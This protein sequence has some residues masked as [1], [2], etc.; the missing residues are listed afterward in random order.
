MLLKRYN[1]RN[2]GPHGTDLAQH[3][4][5]ICTFLTDTL[6]TEGS[7]TPVWGLALILDTKLNLFLQRTQFS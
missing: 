2:F 1:I 3:R 7:K 6:Q 5:E 4:A